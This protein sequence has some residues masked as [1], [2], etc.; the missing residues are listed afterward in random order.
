MLSDWLAVAIFIIII[1]VMKSL[2]PEPQCQLYKK[3][4]GPEPPFQKP[5]AKGPSRRAGSP[6]CPLQLCT[7]NTMRLKGG[8]LQYGKTAAKFGLWLPGP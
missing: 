3:D 2:F 5:R 8:F 6:L 4:L 7:F 1:I